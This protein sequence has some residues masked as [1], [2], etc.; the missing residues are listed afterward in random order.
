MDGAK[1]S[2]S[3]PPMKKTAEY[4]KKVP[5]SRLAREDNTVESALSKSCRGS[6]RR[7]FSGAPLPFF[8]FVPIVSGHATGDPLLNPPQARY[9]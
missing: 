1:G 5:F 2:I 8:D 4:A 9:D 6:L 7:N 3:G